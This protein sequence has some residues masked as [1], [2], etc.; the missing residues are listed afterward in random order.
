MRKFNFVLNNL[1]LLPYAKKFDSDIHAQNIYSLTFYDKL[2]SI[3][4]ACDEM[5]FAI[6][7]CMSV[8]VRK[9]NVSD[10]YE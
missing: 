8:Y 2:R 9:E 6:N 5:Y 3:M 4:N 1:D 7:R 10:I